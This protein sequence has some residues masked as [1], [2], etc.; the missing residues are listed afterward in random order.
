MQDD[1]EQRDTESRRLQSGC[2]QEPKE[3]HEAVAL[4]GRELPSTRPHL[5]A[6]LVEPRA[7]TRRHTHSNAI[8]GYMGGD[9]SPSHRRGRYGSPL[10]TSGEAALPPMRSP[11][12]VQGRKAMDLS[13]IDELLDK[14]IALN[15]RIEGYA[16]STATRRSSGP[17]R[18]SSCC[19]RR[20]SECKRVR[21]AS[22][23]PSRT[24]CSSR[25]SSPS[26]IWPMHVHPPGSRACWLTRWVFVAMHG[27]CV[28][29]A[30]AACICVRHIIASH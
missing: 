7:G 18:S 3:A 27:D 29:A 14:Q 12:V 19:L 28:R 4:I 11:K 8:E 10:R 23:M 2:V 9:R 21:T 6:Q 17:K 15:G 20:R 30:A 25:T 26:N 1:T 22:R 16:R 5:L 13:D 24:Y